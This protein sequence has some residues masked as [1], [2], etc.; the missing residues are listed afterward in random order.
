MRISFSLIIL[1]L[2]LSRV[3][4]L[5]QKVSYESRFKAGVEDYKQGRFGPSMEKLSPL[6]STPGPN[7]EY[8]HYYYALSAYQSK[9]YK[10]SR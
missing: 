5:G 3:D 7:S 8:A 10:E 1:L 9:K 6:T 2:C 4:L